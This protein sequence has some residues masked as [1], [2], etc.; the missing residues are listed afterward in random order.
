M[1]AKR[2]LYTRACER[3]SMKNDELGHSRIGPS[4]PWLVAE[5]F[6]LKYPGA[7]RAAGLNG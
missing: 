7:A 5:W 6:N 2:L 3:Q 4:V 1:L